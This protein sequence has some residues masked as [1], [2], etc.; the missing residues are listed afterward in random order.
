MGIAM[1]SAILAAVGGSTVAGVFLGLFVRRI[2]HRLND[3]ILGF[4]A[5]IMLAAAVFGLVTPAFGG[6]GGGLLLA[7]A[8]TFC[9]AGFASLLDRVVPHLHRI[10]G[11]D[12]ETHRTNGTIDKTLLFV[13]AIALHKIPEGLATGASFAAGDVGDAITV[14]GSITLQNIPEA[15]VIVA[16]L[17]AIGLTPARVMCISFA[18]ASVS[19]ASVLAGCMLAGFF[20]DAM[21]FMLAA[22]GGAMLYVISDEMIPETHSHGYEKPATFALIS[23]F[24][25]VVII[26]RLLEGASAS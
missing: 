24:V 10:A 4:A 21:P 14:A 12:A 25:L 19:V 26:Q 1:M 9:G 5:G 18:V 15:V 16:P 8:G 17:F 22:A 2:P 20:A 23:G 7:V 13:A 6:P 11:I 3:V